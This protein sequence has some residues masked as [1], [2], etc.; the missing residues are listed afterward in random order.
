MEK[1]HS[2]PAA[3]N[4]LKTPQTYLSHSQTSTMMQKHKQL[5]SQLLEKRWISK[6]DKNSEIIFQTT[7]SVFFPY[8]LL[9]KG[10]KKKIEKEGSDT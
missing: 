6:W 9:S 10:K 8:F 5:P 4:R 3:G 7:L 1:R 2:A